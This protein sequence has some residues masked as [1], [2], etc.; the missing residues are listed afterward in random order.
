MIAA[1][2][3]A[4]AAAFK[5]AAEWMRASRDKLLLTLGGT[6]QKADDLQ[7]RLDSINEANKARQSVLAKSM[8]NPKDD[9]ED[10]GF[11]RGDDNA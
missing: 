2:I 8:K 5:L 3:S 7:S 10:D 4:L 11:M 6:R 1:I 9:L